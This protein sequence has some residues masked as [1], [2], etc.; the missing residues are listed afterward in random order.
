MQ[1]CLY[2][3]NKLKTRM[4]FFSN[5]LSCP[6][7]KLAMVLRDWPGWG[8]SAAT[9]A[10][11]HLPLSTSTC[12]RQIMIQL[13]AVVCLQL[14]NSTWVHPTVLNLFAVV[15]LP[16]STSTCTRQI[17]IQ[18]FAVVCLQLSNSTWV[19]PTVLH[20]FAVVFLPLSTSMCTR[21]III[22]LFAVECLNLS[23]STWVRPTVL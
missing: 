10:V 14:S 22:Q 18:L 8:R 19:R 7:R 21:Q 5:F 16:P 12:T 17:M 9:A 3:P 11:V 20:L 4:H 13:F 2:C 23:N 6:T 1:R 15:H